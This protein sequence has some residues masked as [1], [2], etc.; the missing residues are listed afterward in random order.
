MRIP[1]PADLKATLA[2]LRER[3][4]SSSG[5][6]VTAFTEL[7]DQLQRNP[8]APEVL[9]AVRRELHRLHGTAGSYGFHEASR[10]AGA[11]EMVAVKWAA[12]PTLD[13]A[14]RGAVLRQFA[15]AVA[16]ALATTPQAEESPLANRLLL[17][18][19]SDAIAA[20]LVTEGMQRGYFVERVGAAALQELLDAGLPQVVIA[21]AGVPVSVPEDL[22]LVLLQEGEVEVAPHSVRARVVDA[23]TDPR[24]VLLIAESLAAHTGMA[25]ANILVVDDDPAMLDLLRAIGESAGMFMV[26]LPDADRL[27]EALVEH[28]PALLLM[29][30]GLPGVDGLAATR[31]LRE[32]RRFVELPLVLVSANSDAETRAAAFAAGADDFQSK[33]V[34]AAEVTRR[35]ARLLEL[36]RQRLL[37]RGVHPATGLPLPGRTARLFDEAL[38]AASGADAPH[39]LALLRPR[40]AIDGRHRSATWHRECT[41]LA[42]ELQSGGGVIGFSDESS[43]VLFLPLSGDAMAARLAPLAEAAGREASSWCAGVVELGVG[44]DPD[45]RRLTRA[46]EEAWTAARDASVAVHRWADADALIAPDVILVEDDE[47]LADL[48]SYALSARGLT[49]QVFRTGPAALAGLRHL[50]VHGRR[51]VVLLD[52]DLPGLDGFSLFERLRVDR[53]GVYQV[54]FLSVRSSEADQLRALRAGALDYIAK[55]VSLRVLMAKISVWRAQ[56]R[57]S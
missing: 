9:D 17:V 20:P 40:E 29:D 31:Q 43:L 56:D 21:A 52:V 14:R 33:P 48:V 46:A 45:A 30:I 28:R 44:G 6:T 12:D 22:P 24:E 2:K 41:A 18:E 23:R 11:L 10:I 32:D 15:R 49:Y 34:V 53:P 3:F 16:A 54:V 19:L 26:T 5:N 25:G 8:A 50:R 37:S 36:H 1:S 13:L 47:A 4:A 7:A 27:A 35:I 38:R 39:A 55:P 42:S 51:P 57:A